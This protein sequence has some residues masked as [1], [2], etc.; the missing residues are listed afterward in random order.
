MAFTARVT[1]GWAQGSD[2]QS[3]TQSRPAAALL[4]IDETV[5]AAATHA[6]I[7]CVLATADIE[8][9]YIVSDMDVTLDTNATD[10]PGTT[11][12]LLA[13]QP[14]VWYSD[15][16]YTNLLDADVTALFLSNDDTSST[17]TFT[18]RAVYDP[19]P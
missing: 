3:N 17:A 9:I 2:L 8:A 19:T 1:E 11:I 7:A 13:N 4:A 10:S 5:A 14:Y 6:E 12:S 18:L 15:S 16:Y